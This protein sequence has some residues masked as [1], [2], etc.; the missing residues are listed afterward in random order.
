MTD[1]D[2]IELFVNVMVR[3]APTPTSILERETAFDEACRAFDAGELEIRC[4]VAGMRAAFEAGRK[5]Q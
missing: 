3:V 5:A 4:I 2:L 1:R